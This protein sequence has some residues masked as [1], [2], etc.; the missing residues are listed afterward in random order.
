MSMVQLGGG[1]VWP[2]LRRDV[3]TDQSTWIVDEA[4]LDA[5]G[6]KCVM[7]GNIF[8][9]GRPSAA[10]TL[11]NAGG[12]IHWKAGN[13]TWSN[14]ST[15]ARVGIQDIDAASGP[16]PVGD[17][18]YDVRADL[19]QPSFTVD[20]NFV[21]AAMTTGS[22]SITHGDKL[23]VVI[24]MTA[25]GGSDSV[26]VAGFRNGRGWPGM[27]APPNT[28]AAVSSPNIIFEFDDGTLGWFFGSVGGI[29]VGNSSE[30]W[31]DSTNPDERGNLLRVPWNCEIDALVTSIAG[32]TSAS[33][34]RLAIYATPLGTPTELR[35]VNLLGEQRVATVDN[36]QIYPITTI[37]LSRDTDY[38][39][40]LKANS[41][42]TFGGLPVTLNDA[43]FRKSFGPYMQYAAYA[44]R[45]GGSGSFSTTTT[46]LF[47]ATG[48]RISAIETGPAPSY[49]L[50]I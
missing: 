48:F 42:G 31:Q 30:S 32:N 37:R 40:A 49:N 34:G 24:E 9:D 25:R 10:K 14:A 38:V 2:V 35:G 33:D 7:W 17:G 16:P 1:I 20:N 43:N 12:K 3:V 45:N 6:E 50:G 11:S 13:G 27:S 26:L 41:T 36:Q 8:I 5:V 21:S 44:T 18:S 23:A 28:S 47:P 4:T 22:K 39:V 29:S 15:V 19:D 46:K